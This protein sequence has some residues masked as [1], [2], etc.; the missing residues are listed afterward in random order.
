MNAEMDGNVSGIPQIEVSGVNYEVG[1]S[2]A[3]L[4]TIIGHVRMVFFI[5]LFI[6]DSFFIPFGGVN[7]MPSWV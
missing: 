4:S 3:L 2:K 1:G 7:S 5:L 6:G